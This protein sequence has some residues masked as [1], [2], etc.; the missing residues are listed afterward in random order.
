MFQ[1][2]KTLRR[3]AH[4]RQDEGFT[5]IE[6]MVVVLIIGILAGIAIVAFNGVQNTAKDNRAKANLRNVQTV[7]TS[8]VTQGASGAPASLAAMTA[9]NVNTTAIGGEL[10]LASAA[11]DTT[12]KAYSVTT[13]I[14][15][16]QGNSTSSFFVLDFTGSSAQRYTNATCPTA[17]PTGGTLTL[18]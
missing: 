9:A 4:K 5:L 1:S 2:T 12:G 17:T 7:A 15:C 13:G 8:I 14:F 11:V 3:L 18:W 16:A 10:N 6:L